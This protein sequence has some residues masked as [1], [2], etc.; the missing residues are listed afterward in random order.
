MSP[1][2]ARRR[3]AV[4]GTGAIVT[5]GHLPALRA[6]AD[7]T[8]LVAAVDVDPARLD[9]FRAEA[10]GDVA[11]TRRWATCWTPYGPTSSSS[12]R[13]PPCTG[14]RRWPRSRR[15][16]GCCARS[17]C[18]SRW[19]ST[20]TSRRPRRH[21]GRTRPSSSSTATDRAPRTPAT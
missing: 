3:V 2:P 14:S 13:R 10:G 11:G 5:G 18:A 1:R 12:A 19:P 8:E 6:H 9:A 7:R 20:T 4:V 21:P 15:A 17:R 16:P